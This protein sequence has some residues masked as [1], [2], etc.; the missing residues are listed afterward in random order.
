MRR[1]SISLPDSLIAK[2]EP[3]RD[4][5]NISQLCRAALERRVAAYERTADLDGNDLGFD[6]LVHWIREE[7][8]GR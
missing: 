3:I 6:A 2:L 4:G 1:I 5:V 8:C 7:I